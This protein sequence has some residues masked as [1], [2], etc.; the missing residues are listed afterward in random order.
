MR[1]LSINCGNLIP[2]TKQYNVGLKKIAVEFTGPF[3]VIDEWNRY[4]I[5]IDDYLN[6]WIEAYAIQSL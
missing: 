3:P 5:H 4:I 6:K 2:D 1:L